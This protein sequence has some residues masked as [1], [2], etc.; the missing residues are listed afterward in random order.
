VDLA[1]RGVE[2]YQAIGSSYQALGLAELGLSEADGDMDLRYAAAHAAWLAG[3]HDDAIEHARRLEAD[4]DRAGDVERRAEARR[5]LMRLYWEHGLDAE[6]LATTA[7][8][9]ASL[10]ELG[11]SPAHARALG[12]LAQEAMLDNRIDETVERA[13]LAIEAAERHDLVDVRLAA[14]VDKGSALINRR[15]LIEE[16]IDLLLRT[17]EE[18][19]AAGEHLIASR[20]WHN[21]AFQA[22]GRLTTTERLELFERMREAAGRAGWDKQSS[23]A[24]I[25]GRIELAWAE[26]DMAEV[27]VWTDEG[28]RIDRSGA[29]W[30]WTYLRTIQLHLE[31][32]ESD[33]A[34]ALADDMPEMSR[35]KGEMATALQM[36]VAL[37]C[38]RTA[39]ARTHL[40]AL[41]AKAADDG[42]D[43]ISVAV[44]VPR[45]LETGLDAG[46]L[47]PLV[48]GIR[49]WGGAEFHASQ[50]WQLRFGAHLA[51]AAGDADRAI[52]QFD[53]VFAD[54]DVERL[55]WASEVATDH[56]GAAR[57]LLLARRDE[58]AGVHADEAAR[59]LDRWEGWR[60]RSLEALER[61]LGRR[62]AEPTEGPIELTPRER[63]VLAL[64]AEGLTNAELAERLYISPRTAG[65]HVSN[66][67]S[68]LG[69]SSRTEAA[70]WAVRSGLGVA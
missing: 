9:E 50:H 43:A 64:V 44:V 38:G 22:E 45:A 62:G 18:A 8:L 21:V 6:R 66:I 5:L 11:D 3:L 14:L 65:V 41:H 27:L 34:A 54:H 55:V 49:R 33:L 51:L 30:G 23:V 63:E 24:Y 70:A 7:A 61:R 4:A 53:R 20:A 59:R 58:E 2:H 28:R 25:E 48:D 10:D 69:M 19:D 39:D 57:A 67:L 68:K 40:A 29:S 60:V 15:E 12:A 17:A 16:N 31:R 32:S 46:D 1:R 47:Q 35:D 37:E 42:L 56:I 52:E 26:A 13:E 36:A